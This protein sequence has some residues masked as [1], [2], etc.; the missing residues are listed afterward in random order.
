MPFGRQTIWVP[1]PGNLIA[2]LGFTTSRP[3]K[4]SRWRD[5][6][7]SVNSFKGYTVVPFVGKYLKRVLELIP[8]EYRGHEEPIVR[9]VHVGDVDHL[10]VTDETWAFFQERYGLGPRDEEI[11]QVS[12][13]S[14]SGLPFMINCDV[15]RRLV[16]V[17][18]L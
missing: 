2:G 11:F 6:A 3:S 1:K 8:A 14:V 9:Q 12:L 4:T 15:A 18:R 7:S 10:S 13:G 17:D 16:E 5:L